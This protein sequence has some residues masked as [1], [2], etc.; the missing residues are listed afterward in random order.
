MRNGMSDRPQA[1]TGR[2]LRATQRKFGRPASAALRAGS[3]FVD[4]GLR[5][6]RWAHRV[7]T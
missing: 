6:R 1:D 5:G 2:C 7:Q 4:N 3:A